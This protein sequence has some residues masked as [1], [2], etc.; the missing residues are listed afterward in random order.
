MRKEK[1]GNEVLK[2]T[3]DTGQ[4]ELNKM[5]SS[6]GGWGEDFSFNKVVGSWRQSN[7]QRHL[8]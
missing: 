1:M 2:R 5:P 6:L 8:N 3:E 4:K 7:R